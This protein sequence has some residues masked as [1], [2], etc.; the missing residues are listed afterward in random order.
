MF[1]K[2]RLSHSRALLR[3]TNRLNVYQIN[4]QEHPNF[5]H[6]VKN[7]ETARIFNDVIK[8]K[9]DQTFGYKMFL[10]IEQSTQFFFVV[11]SYGMNS[12]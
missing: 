4:L 9:K 6:Q 7:Q 1:N 8:K 5:I 2:D 11:Q 10:L 3:K 12:P